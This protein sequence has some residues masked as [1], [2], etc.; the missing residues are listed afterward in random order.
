MSRLPA[1]A[2]DVFVLPISDVEIFYVAET[3][4]IVSR[5]RVSTPP[6]AEER[7]VRQ[8]PGTK[9]ADSSDRSQR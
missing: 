6:S 8:Q 7:L 4:Q 3:H 1:P 2:S 9:A 5:I